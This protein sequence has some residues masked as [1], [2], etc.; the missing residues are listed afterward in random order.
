[1]ALGIKKRVLKKNWLKESI[2]DFPGGSVN[3]NS[4]ANAGDTG[5]TPDPEGS[6]CHGAMKSLYH[7]GWSLHSL[8]P[9][10]RNNRNHHIKSPPTTTKRS[11]H[12]ATGESWWA[13]T[14]TQH[15]QN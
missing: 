12:S 7:S 10:L 9:V 11:P 3:E 5:L 1:M 14:K 4:P 6:A 8:Q 2:K 13:A 15:S